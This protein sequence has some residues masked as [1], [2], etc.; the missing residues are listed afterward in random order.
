MT[1]SP[2]GIHLNERQRLHWLQLIRCENIG[3]IT[4]HELIARYGTAENALDALP[5]IIRKNSGKRI[6]IATKDDALREMERADKLGIRFIGI[7][8]PEYPP[9]L[10]ETD[11]APPLIAVRGNCE[12][13]K[14]TAVGIV[15]SR[16]SSAVGLR[17]TEIFSRDLGNAG[18]AVISGLAR[19]IDTAA[20]KS[21]LQ[22][23]TIAI[24]AGGVDWI[25]P[26][27]NERLYHD[28]ISTG[29]AIISEMPIGFQP[30]ATDF[31]R[32][33]RLV[34]G[35]ALGV[36]VAEA[37]YKSGSLITARL[38]NEMGRIVFA[39]PGSPLDPRAAGTNK[40]IK[41]GALLVTNAQDI[42]ETLTPLTPPSPIQNDLFETNETA[43]SK[44]V[45]QN[46]DV[47]ITDQPSAAEI[48]PQKNEKKRLLRSL[49]LTP[50]DLETLSLHSG[51][52]LQELYLCL[53]ELDL[54][55]MIIRHPGGLISL[56]PQSL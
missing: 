10:R 13:L 26:T 3:P 46:I 11:S 15:G 49:S 39:I 44:V 5:D 24:L 31:P 30:R 38:A 27:E 25:Y 51:F 22:T 37:A 12:I 48:T 32:R 53:M 55:K 50:V 7:G 6:C 41:E 43:L 4:F 47:N 45:S 34:A 23:G 2:K 28:I 54:D 29:G 33:N 35:I 19:G 36:L 17:L 20:H 56:A 1:G 40:L 8:E 52:S 14:R 9:F 18:L 21:A 16:N 42:I